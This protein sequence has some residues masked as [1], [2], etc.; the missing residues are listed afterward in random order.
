MYGWAAPIS[1]IAAMVLGHV[2]AMERKALQFSGV[3]GSR[4]PL[5]PVLATRLL[6]EVRSRP[7]VMAAL[8]QTGGVLIYPTKSGPVSGGRK[9]TSG[10]LQILQRRL[11]CDSS[12][13]RCV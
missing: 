7:E 13:V 11:G 9:G 4:L 1:C 3:A 12:R 8:F 2:P 5:I 6:M 10:Y